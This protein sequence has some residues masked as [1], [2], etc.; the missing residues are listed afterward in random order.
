MLLL[1][2]ELFWIILYRQ[3]LLKLNVRNNLSSD[4][5][6]LKWNKSPTKESSTISPK[7]QQED[8]FRKIKFIC[9]QK[10]HYFCKEF[11]GSIAKM[12]HTSAESIHKLFLVKKLS[13]YSNNTD[14]YKL[15]WVR[16]QWKNQNINFF[17]IFIYINWIKDE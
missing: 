1:M 16:E 10:K 9:Y 3:I 8:K 4:P 13:N 2:D 11:D 14:L 15:L 17:N 7:E 12:W 6:S 5:I